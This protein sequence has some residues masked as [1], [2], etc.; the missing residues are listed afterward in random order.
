MLCAL[1]VLAVYKEE[2]SGKRDPRPHVDVYVGGKTDRK[3][4]SLLVD[5][6]A[7]VS[8]MSEMFDK[9]PGK[10]DFPVAVSVAKN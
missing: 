2:E 5:T 8:V 6:G 9:L 4:F 1:T 10:K 3:K 7:G